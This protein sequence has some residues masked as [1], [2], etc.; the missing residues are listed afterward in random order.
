M[1]QEVGRVTSSSIS[2]GAKQVI[3]SLYSL[4]KEKPLPQWLCCKKEADQAP[5]E[6]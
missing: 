1:S 6:R 5:S 4:K 3:Q 2:T